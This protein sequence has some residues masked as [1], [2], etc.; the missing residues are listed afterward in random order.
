MSQ[1]R[2]QPVLFLRS[3]ARRREVAAA[4]TGPRQPAYGWDTRESL[5]TRLP[6]V[7]ARAILPPNLLDSKDVLADHV[8]PGCRRAFAQVSLTLHGHPIVSKRYIEVKHAGVRRYIILKQS[9][10]C[11][12]LAH[13]RRRPVSVQY[14][15]NSVMTANHSS[16]SDLNSD[17]DLWALTFQEA[18]EW[19]FE[20]LDDAA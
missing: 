8:P 12:L 15:P 1:S 18:L 6:P 13:K 5:S 19:M 4:P 17:D 7:S 10:A 2:V 3:Q 11:L 9:G 14:S 20:F 16:D